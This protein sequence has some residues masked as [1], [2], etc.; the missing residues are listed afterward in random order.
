MKM[1]LSI[2]TVV[3]YIVKEARRLLKT[4]SSKTTALTKA[5]ELVFSVIMLLPCLNDVP[6]QKIRRMMLE[7]V[8]MPGRDQAQ[9]FIIVIFLII[10]LSLVPGAILETHPRPF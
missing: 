4:V 5:E 7:V 2:P 10:P 8:F 3:E 9:N 6:S 1:G